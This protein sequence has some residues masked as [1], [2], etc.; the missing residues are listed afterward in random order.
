[1]PVRQLCMGN[2][3]IHVYLYK[4]RSFSFIITFGHNMCLVAEAPTHLSE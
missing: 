4:P 2:I 1:M 3:Y